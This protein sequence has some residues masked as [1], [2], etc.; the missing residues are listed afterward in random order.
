[1]QLLYVLTKAGIGSVSG[2]HRRTPANCP[3]NSRELFQAAK[4]GCDR[5]SDDPIDADSCLRVDPSILLDMKLAKP[6]GP[7]HRPA[8]IPIREDGVAAASQDKRVIQNGQELTELT[9]ALRFVQ[10]PR[11]PPDPHRGELREIGF[12]CAGH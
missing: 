10:I 5:L 4:A 8:E 12:S 11:T 1:M 2:V 6:L 9:E 3:G 7:D